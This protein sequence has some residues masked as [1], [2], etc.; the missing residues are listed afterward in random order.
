MRG[1]DGTEVLRYHP[2]LSLSHFNYQTKYA[3]SVFNIQFALAPPPTLTQKVLANSLSPSGFSM[4]S[5]RSIFAEVSC[6]GEREGL[7]PI[8]G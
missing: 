8:R 1:M 7:L 5:F 2:N 6:R 3:C 4:L